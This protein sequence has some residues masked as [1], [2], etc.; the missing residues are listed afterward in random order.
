MKASGRAW[1][2]GAGVA[3]TDIV[4]TRYDKAAMS[5]DWEEC[6]KHLFEE[7]VPGFAGTVVPGDVVIV[8][9]ELGRGHA[10]YYA[11]AVTSCRTAGIAALL[12]EEVNALFQRC[13]IDQGFLAW[14]IK[15]ISDFALTGDQVVFDFATGVA[16]NG[17]SGLERTFAPLSP[18]ILEIVQAGGSLEWA[19]QRVAA[20]G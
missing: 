1:T 19:A 7:L 10:H 17:T 15:G 3:A 11:A 4:S 20:R 12:C 6:R 16:R 2:I 8:G 13:A 5:R 14:P 9:G 18:L